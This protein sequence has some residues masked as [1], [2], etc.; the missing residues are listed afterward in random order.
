M[1]ISVGD[2]PLGHPKVYVSLHLSTVEDAAGCEYC[3]LRFISDE[4]LQKQLKAGNKLERG[5]HFI[6]PVD[7]PGWEY[8]ADGLG[9][10]H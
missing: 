4:Y 8:N 2:G 9:G 10:G 5:T 1:C 6:E 7:L 3:G